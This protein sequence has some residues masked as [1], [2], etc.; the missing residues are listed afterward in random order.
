MRN[1]TIRGV[2][3]H[4]EIAGQ[5]IEYCWGYIKRKYRKLNDLNPKNLHDNVIRATSQ[6]QVEHQWAF[7][8]RCRE[9][10]R[11]YLHLAKTSTIVNSYDENESAREHIKKQRTHRNVSELE[12]AFLAEV[13]KA[14]PFL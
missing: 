4:P 14:M 1:I 7:D 6:V 5:G 3:G 12:H 9:H 8:R 2:K 11:A 10:M 13:E